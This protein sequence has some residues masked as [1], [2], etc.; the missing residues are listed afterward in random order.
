MKF[1]LTVFLQGTLH[2]D[3][4]LPHSSRVPNLYVWSLAF[5]LTVQKQGGRWTGESKGISQNEDSVLVNL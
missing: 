3:T 4:A 1:L 5:S 2:G